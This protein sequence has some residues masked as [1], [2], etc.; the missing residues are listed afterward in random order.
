LPWQISFATSLYRYATY[1]SRNLTTSAH[2][3]P[4]VERSRAVVRRAA[5]E[6]LAAGG[7]R[8]FSIDAVAA[9]AGVARSTIYRHWPDKISLLIDALES[10]SDQPPP[11]SDTTPRQRVV[12]LVEHLASAMVDAE[13]SPIVPAL[14]DAAERNPAVRAVHRAFNERRR[15]ALTS[16]LADAGASE[17]ELLARALAGAV[18]YSRIMTDDPLPPRRAGALVDAVL[19]AVDPVT[20]PRGR[21]TPRTRA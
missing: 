18:I 7:W 16:A 9:R 21:R 15:S 4:R 5:V 2:E 11:R 10:H 19:G 3:D 1:V 8:S 6:V 14:V 20:R 12:E 13:R 17:P